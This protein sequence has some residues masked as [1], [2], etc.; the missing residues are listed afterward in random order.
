MTKT[1]STSATDLLAELR[2]KGI[3]VAT[4][5]VPAKE[6]WPAEDTHQDYYAKKGGQPYCHVRTPRF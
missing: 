4:E 2:R 5:V 1:T 6:F 3:Q